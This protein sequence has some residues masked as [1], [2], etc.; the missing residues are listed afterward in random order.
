MQRPGQRLRLRQ[1]ADDLSCENIVK[2]ATHLPETTTPP[3]VLPAI[4]IT[5][6]PI[7][8]R[9]MKSLR[10]VQLAEKCINFWRNDGNRFAFKQRPCAFSP[11]PT[12]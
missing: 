6:R 4:R 7:D 3:M 12:A 2:A 8:Y 9:P 1:A 5:S 10:L 11:L